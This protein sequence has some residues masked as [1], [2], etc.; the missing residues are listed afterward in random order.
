MITAGPQAHIRHSAPEA[1][2]S[3]EPRSSRARQSPGTSALPPIRPGEH[4]LVSEPRN[5]IGRCPPAQR[6]PRHQQQIKRAG[7]H[8]KPRWVRSR[9]ISASHIRQ[10]T[11][12]TG[13]A[14]FSCLQPGFG[15]VNKFKDTAR[16]RRESRKMRHGRVPPAPTA[17]RRIHLT[18][19]SI[20]SPL[21]TAMARG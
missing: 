19:I 3:V 6:F 17:P 4:A 18:L 2:L 5:V 20:S 8:R 1:T 11:R 14:D 7:I 15:S 12:R 21:T 16:I 10:A 13:Y 9:K